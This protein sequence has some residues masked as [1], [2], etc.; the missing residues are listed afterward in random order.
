MIKMAGTFKVMVLVVGLFLVIFIGI[1]LVKRNASRE[2]ETVIVTGMTKGQQDYFNERLSSAFKLER[3]IESG[4]RLM[5]QGQY[6]EAIES[7]QKVYDNATMVGDEGIAMYHL[8]NVYEKMGNYKKALEYINIGIAKYVNDWA[9]G[10]VVERSKYLEYAL[11]GNYDMA[12]KHAEMSLEEDKKLPHRPDKGSPSY[13][14]RL[15]DIKAAKDY[16][17]S[18]K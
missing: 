13:I 4:K 14:Q 8:A 12:V 15:N 18:L 9:K 16:I 7:F 11:Q 17:E 5:E 2:K 6:E 10:P 1:N 3:Y